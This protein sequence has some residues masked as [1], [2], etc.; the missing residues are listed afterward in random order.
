MPPDRNRAGQTPTSQAKSQRTLACVNCQQRKIKCN[1]EFPCANCL[2]QH[3]QCVPA[4][5]TR[6]R[7]RRFPEREL[8]SRLRKYEDLLRQNNVRFDPLHEDSSIKGDGIDEYSE[9]EQQSRPNHSSPARKRTES[10]SEPKNLWQA[11]NQGPRHPQSDGI[12]EAMV[13]M[14]WDQCFENDDHIILGSRKSSV[15]LATMHPEPVHIIRLW[16]LYLENVNP[17]FKVTHTPSLQGMIIEAA[18]NITSIEPRLE[19]LM[20]SIYCIAIQ[21]LTGDICQSIFG[22]S[23]A[24]LLTKYQFGCQQVLLNCQFLRTDN[25]TCLTAFFLFLFSLHSNTNPQSLSSMLGIAI[26]TAQRMGIHS[27]TYLARYSVFEAEMSR[28]LWWALMMFDTRV[29]ELSGAKTS[30]LNPT[31]NCKPPLNINDSDLWA[32]MK[33]PPAVQGKATEAVF[34]VLRSELANYIRHSPFHLEFLNPALK[35]IARELPKGGDVATFEKRIEEEYLKY[36][37]EENPLHFMAIWTMRAHLSKCHLLERYAKYFDSLAHR[38]DTESD[39]AVSQAFR[40][41]ECDTKI[42]TSPL[43]KG[44]CWILQIYFPFPAYI[45]IIQD[46][47]KRPD[48]NHTEKAWQVMNENYGVRF[49]SSSGFDGPLFAIFA[50]LIIEAWEALETTYKQSGTQVPCPEI[51]LNIKQRLAD[52]TKDIP[53]PGS[54]I[55]DDA[56]ENLLNQPMPMPI[57]MGMGMGP[58]MG[59]GFGNESSLSGMAGQVGFPWSD[60]RLL[61]NMPGQPSMPCD[62]HHLNWVSMVWGLREARGW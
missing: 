33:E 32:E 15:D 16:Q 6:P 5:Q 7:K 54:E 24:Q 37:D 36:L 57:D 29:G 53:T 49:N 8:L 61:T 51:V 44:Y 60:P 45:H 21:S 48:S 18:T 55:P 2:K 11:M 25:R 12:R 10:T 40:L 26:R 3:T 50:R 56:L 14:S 34:A 52:M 42:L 31:W 58:G 13:R 1:R 23:K 20:F 19:A 27:E 22:L 41:L 43:T 46:L 59:M 35:P 38:T 62:F 30:T 28:R 47:K 4:S 17:L 39:A 9:E